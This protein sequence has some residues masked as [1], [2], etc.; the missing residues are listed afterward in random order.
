MT[1]L[2]LAPH[3]PGRGRPS[4]RLWSLGQGRFLPLTPFPCRAQQVSPSMRLGT[5]YR[6]TLQ[7]RQEEQ[8]HVGIPGE[9]LV[10]PPARFGSTQRTKKSSLKGTDVQSP[11]AARHGWE[12]DVVNFWALSVVQNQGPSLMP[13][14]H[15]R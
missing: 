13:L 5:G 10:A 12:A 11:C 1:R 7:L 14:G 15:S 8:M 6:G 4:K 2:Q 9:P 3:S